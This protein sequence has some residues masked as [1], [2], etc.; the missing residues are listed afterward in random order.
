MAACFQINLRDN[1]ATALEELSPGLVSIYGESEAMTI[2]VREPVASGH[3]LALKDIAEGEDIVKYGVV[4]GQATKNI[5]AGS[6][7]HLQNMRSGYDSR[8]ATLDHVT[9][10]PSDTAYD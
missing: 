5:Q 3:K 6:W 10:A 9:G 1:V 8:S 2:S 7:V 4:I